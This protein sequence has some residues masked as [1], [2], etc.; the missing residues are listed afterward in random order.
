[1]N[2]NEMADRMDHAARLLAILDLDRL[3]DASQAE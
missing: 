3:T 1:V 2:L